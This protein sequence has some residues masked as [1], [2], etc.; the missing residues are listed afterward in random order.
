MQFVVTNEQ[1]K[2]AERICAEE[3][4]SYIRLMENAGIACAEEI[5]KLVVM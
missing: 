4:V 1:M 2:N 5:K 3:S